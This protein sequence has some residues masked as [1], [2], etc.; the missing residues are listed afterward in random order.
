MALSNKVIRYFITGESVR[1]QIS[2]LLTIIAV[3]LWAHSILS[4]FCHLFHMVKKATGLKDA[5][6]QY[7]GGSRGWLRDAPQV[8][9]EGLAGG[10]GNIG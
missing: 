8:Y 6:L 10:E 5:E 7:T 3:L 1:R 4:A 9:L 2:I